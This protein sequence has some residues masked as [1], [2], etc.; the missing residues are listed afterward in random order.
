M[1][2][3]RTLSKNPTLHDFYSSMDLEFQNSMKI[4]Q[5]TLKTQISHQSL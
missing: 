2:V 3:A 5:L 1:Q 4:V